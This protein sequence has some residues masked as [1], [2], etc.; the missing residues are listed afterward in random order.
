MLRKLCIVSV[1]LL[2]ACS[3]Q[4][5][6]PD[7]PSSGGGSDQ[8]PV[9]DISQIVLYARSAGHADT[10]I[11]WDI[12][13]IALDRAD[14]SR[15]EVPGTDVT[16]NMADLEQGQKLLAVSEVEEG[17]YTGLSIFARNIYYA[18]TEETVPTKTMVF[19]IEQNLV[20]WEAHLC[21]KRALIQ[22]LGNRQAAQASGVQRIRRNQALYPGRRSKK[23]QALHR[24]QKGRRDL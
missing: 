12:R 23:V 14:G 3:S 6:R 17:M 15:I 24:G 4:V 21:R 1:A 18:D 8:V 7:A 5:R 11:V 9:P 2:M 19:S 10:P 22:H 13:K 16:V 20:R